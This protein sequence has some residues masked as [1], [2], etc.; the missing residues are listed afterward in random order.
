MISIAATGPGR[1]G[2][3][4]SA[5]SATAV[6]PISAPVTLIPSSPEKTVSY[7]SVW[8]TLWS[9]ET[10]MKRKE[11]EKE[12][13]KLQVELCTLQDW[14]KHHGLRVVVIFEGRDAAGKGG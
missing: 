4:S 9:S 10:P 11:Y 7:E 2:D 5:R 1:R 8:V 6:A 12:L 14:I 13:R 3:A